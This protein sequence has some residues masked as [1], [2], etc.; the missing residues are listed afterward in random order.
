MKWYRHFFLI[1]G[2][3]ASFTFAQDPT[4][5]VDVEPNS[6]DIQSIRGGIGTGEQ[7]NIAVRG[8]NLENVFTLRFTINFDPAKF[9]YVGATANNGGT[10]EENFLEGGSPT[11]VSFFDDELASGQMQITAGMVGGT[12]VSGAGLLAYFTFTSNLGEGG[13]GTF[14]VSTDGI[15]IDGEGAT[16]N[17]SSYT[18]GTIVEGEV[19]TVTV[20][21]GA[22]GSTDPAGDILVAG[23]VSLNIEA[24]P[25]AGF[26]FADWAVTGDIIVDDNDATGE[27]TINS[28]GTITANFAQPG[29]SVDMDP[30][31]NGIQ[32]EIVGSATGENFTVAI[33]GYD[34]KDVRSYSFHLKFDPAE[35]E[36]VSAS[37]GGQ[38]FLLENGATSNTFLPGLLGNNIVNV[39]N[40]IINPDAPFMV[41]GGGLLAVITF[42]S[43]LA[44]GASGALSLEQGTTVDVNDVGTN[45]S[46]FTDGTY[47]SPF[48]V[49]V[50]SAGN[51]TVTPSGNIA[52]RS[53]TDLNV[54]AE[55]DQYYHFAGW[56]VTGSIV[57][58]SGDETGVFTVNGSA[59]I[60]GTFIN[61]APVLNPIGSQSTAEG[62]LLEFTAS[63][64]DP[65]DDGVTITATGLPSGATF[66]GTDFSWTPD[67]NA[68][69]SSPY[70]VTFTASDGD[71]TDG[72]VV[73][74][75]V[76]NTN[77]APTISGTPATTV[78]ED[79]AY[80]FTPTANDVDG[81]ALTFSIANKPSWASFSTTTGALT[82][83]PVNADVGTY[84]GIVITVT[85]NESASASL[86]AFAITVTNVNDAPVITGQA[87]VSTKQETPVTIVL[88]DLTVTDVD[89]TYPDDFT[90]TVSAG[91]NYAVAGATVTPAVGFNGD[92]TVPVTVNDGAANSNT[93]NLIVFVSQTAITNEGNK[94][95]TGNAFLASPNVVSCDNKVRLFFSGKEVVNAKLVIYDALGHELY[96]NS[97]RSEISSETLKE[98]DSWN[99]KN[100]NGR[101]VACGTYIAFLIVNFDNGNLE[102]FK[103]MFGVKE[104]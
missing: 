38:N 67:Y 83:T 85:D 45:L 58:V 30:A 76:T 21:A 87:T 78:A 88:G 16:T 41:D 29:M 10:S 94:L 60:E 63:A 1:I 34:L 23:G 68:A 80:S 81:G 96:K 101:K 33:H 71:L 54:L 27:F 62:T 26:H 53:G 52:V 74:I 42:K 22:N 51:G 32:T 57:E 15:T 31:T 25:D 61:Q 66:D 9:S 59:T 72:E 2:L 36:Y 70:S 73:E 13:S 92:L 104:Y 37:E 5:S 99:L 24:T 86:P 77:N 97:Y 79:A 3:L 69:A 39:G 82:G 6:V 47:H 95:S 12:Q 98:F 18:P 20:S 19:Y 11:T 43:L 8:S 84:T 7:F 49:V 103:T 89:N 28:N 46:L 64:T 65:D 4:F 93:Y 50:S 48:F 100:L 91:T 14:T 35:F 44:E 40:T 102:K 55:P 75:T 17:I 56:S 90:L